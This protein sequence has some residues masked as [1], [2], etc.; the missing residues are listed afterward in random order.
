MEI[1]GTLE[2]FGRYHAHN[3]PQSHNPPRPRRKNSAV[4]AAIFPHATN[5][6]AP[7]AY[8]YLA[9]WLGELLAGGS[10]EVNAELVDGL[11]AEHAAS[12]TSITPAHVADHLRTS[13]DAL[14]DL[15]K[16]LE[17]GQLD[18]GDGRVRRLAV[19][20]DRHADSHRDEIEAVLS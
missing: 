7:H 12:T 17:P 3:H 15:I 19:I 6:R 20:A 16:N 4:H 8:E 1:C 11:N 9:G 14:I 10:P 2:P 13:G 5:L 18:L